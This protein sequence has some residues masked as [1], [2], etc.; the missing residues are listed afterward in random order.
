[1][2]YLENRTFDEISI[3]QSASVERTLSSRDIE[4][5]AV[6]SG[7]VNPAHLDEEFAR[8]GIFHKVIAHGM[9]GGALI[10]SLLGTVLPGPG[11]IYLDQTLKFHRPVGVGD[12]LLVSI[13][14]AARDAE[15]KHIVF[16]CRCTNQHGKTVIDGT[17]TVLAPTEKVRRPRPELPEILFVGPNQMLADTDVVEAAA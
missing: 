3:G 2:E 5:F 6:M 16:D 10:S 15:R 11:T 1:M 17:A 13:S 12:T 7:D 9:W 4:L 8:G 14:A